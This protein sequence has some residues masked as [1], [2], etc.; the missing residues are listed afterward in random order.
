[1]LI[2]PTSNTVSA[3]SAVPDPTAVSTTGTKTL[4]QEDFLKLL[5]VQMQAQDPLQPM[6]DTEF[7]SQMATFTSL[8]QMTD[9]NTSFSSFATQQG[10]VD[11]TTYLGKTVTLTDPNA[12]PV[13]G[14][15]TGVNYATGTP[16]II[17]DGN[18]YDT[19]TITSI[20]SSPTTTATTP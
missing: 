18:S 17:V 9:L 1:M 6:Q 13:T 12:G 4:G 7:I 5:A 2:S 8:Q 11:A 15:V 16:Q 10:S 14:L 20:Q 19:T 3:S